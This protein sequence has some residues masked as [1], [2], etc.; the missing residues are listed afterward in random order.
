MKDVSAI[1]PAA[2][3]GLRL[4]KKVPKALVKVN[5]R[6]IFIHTLVKI[7]Q[8]PYV[9][10]I[11]VVAP[12]KYKGVFKNYIR[13]F[14]IAKKTKVISGGLTR[15][16]S[17]ENGL[18]HID[19]QCH[20]ILIHDAVRPFVSYKL[21]SAVV[22][23]ARRH[24]AAVLGLPV[25]AT[26]KKSEPLRG[27]RKVNKGIFVVKTVNRDN[28]WEIQTPQVFNKRLILKAFRRFKNRSFTDDA[29]L[30]EKMGVRVA[31]VKGSR[32]NIKI[33]TPEDLLIARSIGAPNL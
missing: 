1:I 6:P 3:L 32:F 18:S 5:R 31:L 29:S 11:I 23:Q 8:H 33:T 21:I 9:K 4:K 22:N 16:E 14:R 2:G 15:R 28:L 24:K 7:S 17:V 13:K 12:H 19:P 26:L 10:E 20:L 27:A 30:V 25:R